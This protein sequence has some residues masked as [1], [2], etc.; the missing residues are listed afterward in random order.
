MDLDLAIGVRQEGEEFCDA[1]VF[2]R[3]LAAHHPQ[4]SA[5]DDRVLRRVLDVRIVGHR[6]VGPVELGLR[7][8]IAEEAGRGDEDRALAGGEAAFAGIG[9]AGII[10][11]LVFLQ[12]DQLFEML[13][14][15]RAVEFQH[16][17][18]TVEAVGLGRQ[19]HIV[20]RGQL[21]EVDPGHP[22]IG[23]AA[24]GVAGR[25]QF[26]GVVEHFRPGFRNLGDVRFLQRIEID[27]HHRRRRIEWERQHL[28]L[29]GRVIAG[30]RRQVGLRV[31]F[32]AGLLHEL[33][34]RLHRALCGHHGGGADFEHLHDR[35][36]VTSAECSDAGVHGVGVAALV[37]RHDLELALRGVEIIGQLDDDVVVAAGHGVPPLDLGY[38]VG[39]RGKSQR[40]GCGQRRAKLS[41]EHRDPPDWAVVKSSSSFRALTAPDDVQ[42]TV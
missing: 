9:A 7:L 30:D 14:L 33:V 41:N 37:G 8:H 10:V 42:M 22:G 40:K 28:A 5:A 27:P 19:R 21:F 1:L 3:G 4:R 16:G 6:R 2:F 23:E 12:L 38:G 35:G 11:G 26:L 39:G 17:I 13:Y 25:L 18:E 29:R 36:R 32:L 34:D 24:G 15:Q 20:P 31:E